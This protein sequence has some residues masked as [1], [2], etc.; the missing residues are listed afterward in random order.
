MKD[1]REKVILITG[2]TGGFGSEMCRQFLAEGAWII[3]TDVK[4]SDLTALQSGLD[5]G[6]GRW[7]GSFDVN[8]AD[9]EQCAQVYARASEV[10]S[11]VDILVNNAG[12]APGGPFTE[13]PEDAF[14]KTM[15][16]NLLAPMRL[17]RQFLPGMIERR[18]GHIVN[19]SSA[20]GLT[21]SAMLASYCASKFG[22]RGFGE[23]IAL[24][25]ADHDVKVT[26]VYPFFSRTNILN[27]ERFGDL[28]N[29]EL[30]D[31]MITDPVDIVRAIV[32][33][34]KKDAPAVYPDTASRMIDM[35][36]RIAPA[37]LQWYKQLMRK[38]GAGP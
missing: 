2:A 38:L 18:R 37:G 4:E 17:T 1:L 10:H 20:A 31:W 11:H 27:S 36:E 8:L 26:N 12:I 23:S 15:Q 16:I 25:A 14:E 9:P 33:G 29:R 7:L 34:I 24:E 35:S 19:I 6:S 5:M 21:G 28:A 3:A 30:P 32:R 22:L 13:V